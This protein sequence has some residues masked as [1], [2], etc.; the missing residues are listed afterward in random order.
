ME[1]NEPRLAQELKR[2]CAEQLKLMERMADLERKVSAAKLGSR[3]NE[4]LALDQ[5]HEEIKTE[6]K[7]LINRF[8]KVKDKHTSVIEGLAQLQDTVLKLSTGALALSVTFSSLMLPED[9]S[10]L[11]L[12][13]VSWL[14]LGL[15]IVSVPSGNWL[16]LFETMGISFNSS[17]VPSSL[18]CSA[19]SFPFF[20]FGILVMMI[21]AIINLPW[22]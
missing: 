2:L 4:P 5:E 16:K 20:I 7:D 15:S 21:F 14:F 11:W 13:A 12:L 19:W 18:S 8:E 6:W 1:S 3:E 17:Y 22:R 10:H 9:P